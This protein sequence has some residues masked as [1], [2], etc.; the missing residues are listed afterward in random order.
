MHDLEKFWETLQEMPSNTN[1]QDLVIH[2]SEFMV[3]QDGPEGDDYPSEQ[4]KDQE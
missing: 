3:D 1:V 4:N 2:L